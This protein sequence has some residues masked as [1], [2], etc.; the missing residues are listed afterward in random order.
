MSAIFGIVRFDGAAVDPTDIERM[1][2]T[3]AHRGPHGR[4]HLAIDGAALGHALL[5]VNREDGFEA[6]PLYDA[7]RGLTLVADV[8]LDNREEL[9]SAL[10]IDSS[11]L[12]RM[13]DSVLLLEA[14]RKWGEHCPERLVGDFAFAVWDS[15]VRRLH[16]I[17]DHMGQRCLYLHRGQAFVAFAT[18]IKALWAL[19]GVPR[20]LSEAGIGRRLLFPV[21]PDPEVTLFDGV[22]VMPGGTVSSFDVPGERSDRRFWQPRAEPEHLGHDDDYYVDTYRRVVTEAIACR[23][24]RLDKPPVLLFSGGFDSGII[25]AVAGRLAAERGQH[26]VALASVLP[27]GEKRIVRD[28][29]AAV[30][31][32]A[33]APGFDIH[34]FTCRDESLLTELETGFARDDAAFGTDPVR[35]AAFRLG[36]ARGSRLALDG[37]GGDYTVNARAPAM[38]G[39][40][41]RRGQVRR[42]I[43]EFAG[44]REASG[45]SAAWTLAYEVLP[46][47]VPRRLRLAYHGLR[48][49]LVPQWQRRMIRDEFAQA[50]IAQ[51]AIEP[52]RLR[53]G[54][55]L[56][57]RWAARWL[58]LLDKA[59]RGPVRHGPAAAAEQ[60][61]FSRPFHDPR[62]V[63]FG[64][65]IP[66]RLHLRDG[67]ER[68]LAR[69]AFAAELPARLLGSG[70]GNDQEQPDLYR[71]ILARVGE[72]LA[73]ARAADRGGS[74]SRYVDFGKVEA[75]LARAQEHRLADHADLYVAANAIVA[76][77]FIG[78]FQ[79]ANI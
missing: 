79:Q 49:G 28:A 1:A 64:L 52:S 42:F 2:R 53:H 63:E 6:Q 25:A 12:A 20:R 68:W 16:L 3:L 74:I 29:R 41:L 75:V 45:R 57:G 7:A 31:A 34:Y 58:H 72:E 11:R 54:K 26:V 14:W 50:L 62:V 38:L 51:G 47:F 76:A 65:A 10:G 36:R 27:E 8:R 32:F 18:E 21:D 17:R 70:P 4:E 69:Q 73:M 66:E 35:V 48:R 46:A 22:A 13:A 78:W 33:G 56:E 60:L 9:A 5:R 40:I 39:R 67:R 77:R 37:H 30:D 24:R 15:R 44:R 61:D 59:A 43:G 23:V 19:P 71:S 55:V